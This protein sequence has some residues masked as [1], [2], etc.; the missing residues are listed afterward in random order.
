MDSGTNTETPESEPVE[1][2]SRIS[3]GPGRSDRD[4]TVRWLAAVLSLT[5]AA[6]HFGYAPHHLT[7]D[8]AHGWFFLLVA[9]YQSLFAILVVARPRKWLW[10]SAI[11]VNLGV[12]AT[13]VVSRTAG[14]PI[15][16]DALRSE[17]FSAP[18]IVCAILEG[19]IVLLAA[20]AL[21][22][23]SVLQKP[24]HDRVSLRFASL[25]FG[26][27]AVVLG[28]L[29]LTPA[30]TE[31]H[32][33]DGHGHEAASQL[34]GTSPCELSGPPASPGQV[35]LDAEG[36]AHRGP[37]PQVALTREEREQLAAQQELA[38]SVV[39]K[40]P[41]VAAA[42]AG[43]YRKSTAFIPCIGAHYT[44]IRLALKFDPA[45][46]SELLFDGTNPDSKIVGLSYL[47]WNPGG[48]PE[49]FAG[50]NDVWH[51]H[52]NNGGLCQKG[53]LVIG[54]EAMSVEEC[55]AIG[56]RK[57]ALNDVWMLHNWIVP[58]WECSWGVFAGECPELG[59]RT[60]GT[61]WDAPAPG[62]AGAELAAPN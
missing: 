17:T 40:F 28:A 9:A 59:G 2:A 35:A 46:P 44:N 30:Y 18:D 6:V 49:G 12:L 21:L 56:G 13:W 29:M 3:V 33:G 62:S 7:E 16:P 20:V 45:R 41:N 14:L 60:G 32:A 26:T 22:F 43:G 31:A 15:G 4:R 11:G 37:S 34:D 47:V 10:A 50:G 38:R 36:H 48:A 58:G 54:G 52:N 1:R 27:V 19:G 8:W 5:A 57:V 55:A 42:E 53:G 25:A 39:T 23:P 24:S 61:A 51:Q